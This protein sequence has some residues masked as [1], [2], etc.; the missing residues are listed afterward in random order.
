MLTRDDIE[1]IIKHSLARERFHVSDVAT[2]LMEAII[3][4]DYEVKTGRKTFGKLTRT[5]PPDLKA[6][7]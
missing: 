2:D 5:V 7:E 3:R 1:R 6:M 4:D